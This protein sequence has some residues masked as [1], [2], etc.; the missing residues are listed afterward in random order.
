MWRSNFQF[1]R[2]CR[3]LLLL[4]TLCIPSTLFANE[5]K[6]PSDT[7]NQLESM[8]SKIPGGNGLKCLVKDFTAIVNPSEYETADDS[9]TSNFGLALYFKNLAV[10]DP[11]YQTE[12]KNFYSAVRTMIPKRE[13]NLTTHFPILSEESGS[14][15]A[16]N[17]KPGWLWNLALKNSNG[18][19]KRALELIGACG[20]DDI[21]QGYIP[22]PNSPLEQNA[23]LI[24]RKKFINE[25]LSTAQSSLKTLKKTSAKGSS[26]ELEACATFS[27]KSVA[28]YNSMSNEEFLSG[29]YLFGCT[30]YVQYQENVKNLI[31]YKDNLKLENF[32]IGSLP[33]PAGRDTGSEMADF[34]LSKSLGSQ[35][36]ISEKLKGEITAKS[37][38]GC[39]DKRGFAK[40]E[41]I[42]SKNYHIYGS[43]VI[44]CEM[45]AKG[46]NPKL[47]IE[48]SKLA[49]WYYRVLWLNNLAEDKSDPTKFSPKENLKEA[50]ETL[51]NLFTIGK[52]KAQCSVDD[53]VQPSRASTKDA[54]AL[55]KRWTLSGN[56]GKS[57]GDLYTNIMVSPLAKLDLSLGMRWDRPVEWS[58]SR[59]NNAIAELKSIL[60]D[61]DWTVKQ[62]EIGAEF[63]AS[64]CKP[65]NRKLANSCRGN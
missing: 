32:T 5:A 28:Q 30:D 62:H 3:L 27:S 64:V 54:V 49:G 22:I 15:D 24:E 41:C 63:A 59:F 65:D 20:H 16:S 57:F 51:K 35:V 45:I 23:A 18:N 2:C 31:K 61:F 1:Y 19:P 42:Q 14:G 60:V 39:K 55:L 37:D 36:D 38:L 52:P 21:A 58:D 4:L 11:T 12:L 25:L 48:L 53:Y 26:K 34:F 7:A 44:A 33:C 43:A 56:F 17:L 9:Q 13:T 50:S 6:L 8:L 46:H 40:R 47:V 29:A 10:K